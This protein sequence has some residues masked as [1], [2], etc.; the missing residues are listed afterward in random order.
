MENNIGKLCVN[1]RNINI[2]GQSDEVS[3]KK[4]FTMLIKK[5]T[6]NSSNQQDSSEALVDILNCFN[7]GG[8]NGP[9]NFCQFTSNLR[10]TC[11]IMSS[12]C[13]FQRIHAKCYGSCFNRTGNS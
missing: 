10:L 3:V 8:N 11:F 13:L 5:E 6:W 7:K 12:N 4:L 1:N 2:P 9:F